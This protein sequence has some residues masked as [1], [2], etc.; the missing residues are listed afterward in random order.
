MYIHKEILSI[1][2]KI[3]IFFTLFIISGCLVSVADI[4]DQS[5][6]YSNDMAV[7]FGRLERLKDGQSVP[8]STEELGSFISSDN[9][10]S[11]D[12][13]KIVGQVVIMKRGFDKCRPPKGK[14]LIPTIRSDG[15]FFAV[16]P[17]GKQFINGIC[18][19]DG[20]WK[21]IPDQSQHLATFYAI[22]QKAT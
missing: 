3:P 4:P 16:L 14:N 17:H 20:K 9:Q 12:I 21:L 6:K 18:I 10:S 15:Y 11:D 5:L 1:L 19:K 13:F 7:V 22:P 2:G 8:Y